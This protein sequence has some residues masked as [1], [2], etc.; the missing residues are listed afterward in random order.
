MKNLYFGKWTAFC[1]ITAIFAASGQACP[2]GP[3]SSLAGLW[4]GLISGDVTINASIGA[5]SPPNPNPLTIN[6]TERIESTLQLV[7]NDAGLPTTLPLALSAFEGGF[8]QEAVT[9]FNVGEMQTILGTTTNTSPDGATD[10]TTFD[11]STVTT[12]T[13][14]E[15]TLTADHFRVVYNTSFVAMLSVTGTDPMFEAVSQTQSSTGTLTVDA[16]A[17]GG[18]V[19]FSVDFNINGSFETTS[20]G[21]MPSGNGFVVGSLAGTLAA[22]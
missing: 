5:I 9:A 1:T 18:A 10:T 6:Q 2:P 22:D 15:S 4:T 17:V 8:T 12:L 19:M 16:T 13:V 7:F 3:V 14:V 20:G 11:Q 21:A